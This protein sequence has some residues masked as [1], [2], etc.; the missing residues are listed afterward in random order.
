MSLRAIDKFERLNP[1][2]SVNVFGCDNISQFYPLRI[3]KFKRQKQIYLML[4]ENKH[5][6]CQKFVETTVN[7]N[8]KT[9]WGEC[10][11]SEM[12]QSFSKRENF[13]KA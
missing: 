2:I 10:D 11:L 5:L 1:E 6:S 9:S 3:S 8:L 4:L 7:A 12:P 13:G